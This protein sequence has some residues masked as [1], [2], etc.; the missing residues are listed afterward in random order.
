MVEAWV[1]AAA[2]VVGAGA[3]LASGAMAASASKNA[4]SAQEA[5]ANQANQTQIAEFNATAGLQ[6]PQR[7]LSYGADSL[8]ANLFGL[9]DPNAST[10]T[11]MYGANASLDGLSGQGTS[12]ASNQTS[13]P[14][15]AAAGG[16]APATAT[17][18]GVQGGSGG[19]ALGLSSNGINLGNQTTNT[20]SN[21]APNTTSAQGQFSN[22]YNS[23]GYAF[24]L[25]QGQQSVNRGAAASGSLYSSNNLNQLDQNA[26]GYASQQ[27]N[28]YVNQLMGLAGYGAAGVSAT[29]GAATTAGNNI[30]SNQLSAGNAQ[31]SGILGQAGAYSGAINSTTGLLGNYAQIA[32]GQNGNSLQI[33]GQ[34][35]ANAINYAASNV[36]VPNQGDGIPG[37]TLDQ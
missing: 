14:V 31:A 10:T 27:Y 3:T 22:F 33:Q 15:S 26:Q 37:F 6:T 4:A 17:A 32:S 30:S 25:Q 20:G 35:A 9:P 1:A 16:G 7:N 19:G 24:A 23:P 5:A 2:T 18:Q 8:L 12:V 29:S 34:T 11:S 28:N 36:Q 21:A 13:A